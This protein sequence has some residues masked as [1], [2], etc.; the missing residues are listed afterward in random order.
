L[1]YPGFAQGPQDIGVT[2]FCAVIAASDIESFD[3]TFEFLA[4]E[5]EE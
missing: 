3:R 5:I 2:D 1:Q 4:S